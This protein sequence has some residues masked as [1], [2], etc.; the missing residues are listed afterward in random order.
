MNQME[1]FKWEQKRSVQSQQEREK[2]R[3][4]ANEAEVEAQRAFEAAEK[5]RLSKNRRQEEEAREKELGELE[6]LVHRQA[7]Q[8][9]LFKPSATFESHL[10]AST[11]DASI[12]AKPSG[13]VA[14]ASHETSRVETNS[15]ESNAKGSIR[16]DSSESIY[17]SITRRLNALEGN[18]PLIARYIEEQS[19]VMRSALATLERDWD[20]W[21]LEHDTVERSRWEQEVCARMTL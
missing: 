5:A 14:N 19:R 9:N 21:R 20:D 10:S 17:A 6:R 8:A 7:L 1:A 15:T 13:P 4:A 18:S 16:S 3:S 12:T 2:E 11:P